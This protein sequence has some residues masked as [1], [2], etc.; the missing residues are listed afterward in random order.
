MKQALKAICAT[1]LLGACVAVAEPPSEA[2]SL[3]ADGGGLQPV[4]TPLRIDFGRAEAGAVAAVT[5]LLAAAPSSREA[6][7]GCG[8]STTVVRWA[9][10]F[11]MTFRDD[12]FIG[13]SAA[14]ARG[15]PMRTV[16]GLAPGQPRSAATGATFEETAQG[17][18]L[19]MGDI[20]G[21]LAG[22][23]ID[24]LWAGTACMTG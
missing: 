24:L 16:E 4:G 12:A 17:T 3:R 7:A 13:W 5:R 11:S 6:V 22:D 18:R 8:G 9:N 2:I 20:R 1:V 10:G 23:E 15:T 19:R 21:S 14:K